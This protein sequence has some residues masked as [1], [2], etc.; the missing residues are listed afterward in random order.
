MLLLLVYYFIKNLLNHVEMSTVK[1][2]TVKCSKYSSH[3]CII[4][5]LLCASRG[6]INGLVIGFLL[7]NAIGDD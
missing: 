6:V 5:G 1:M 3:N 7:R 2:F 4:F